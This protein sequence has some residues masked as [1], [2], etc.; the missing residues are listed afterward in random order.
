M[1]CS[2]EAECRK[3][4]PPGALL[5]PPTYHTGHH[6]AWFSKLFAVNASSGTAHEWTALP[7]PPMSPRQGT[8]GAA[9]PATG[10]FYAVGGWS[11]YTP[12]FPCGLADGA[13]L[14]R[15]VDGSWRWT[16]LPDLP[17]PVVF[18]AMTVAKGR[19]FVFG[20]DRYAT[21]WRSKTSPPVCGTF[22]PA[23]YELNPEDNSTW[24]SHAF[25]G[26]FSVSSGA[27]AT[28]GDHL[29]FITGS[30]IPPG[31][32]GGNWK[33]SLT[34]KT[35]TRLA[36]SP[37]RQLSSFSNH[38]NAIF[39]ERYMILVGGCEINNYRNKSLVP[40]GKAQC[41]AG[42]PEFGECSCPCGKSSN[43]SV[44]ILNVSAMQPGTCGIQSH[45]SSLP[46]V[47]GNG[48]FVYDIK[49]DTFGTATVS[50]TQDP[51]LLPAGCG[52]FPSNVAN[53]MVAVSRDQVAVVGGE[54]NTRRVGSTIYQHDSQM[55]LTGEITVLA[56]HGS[57]DAPQVA[58]AVL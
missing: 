58:E 8:C 56:R 5:D 42:S 4:S 39:Q 29:F 28:S 33:F 1:N 34:D 20:A 22:P 47:Y 9:D 7:L 48:L 41:Y 40:S 26:E 23:L 32:P 25:P 2:T 50:A 55:A 17:H 30:T 54:I 16:K 27:L 53:P 38:N 24:A 14:R 18:A 44:D 11:D 31:K 43:S 12:S 45:D 46:M 51:E 57:D 49:A 15:G 21:T 3:L 35:W 6:G 19:V 52:L 37:V 10:S 36:D 13:R